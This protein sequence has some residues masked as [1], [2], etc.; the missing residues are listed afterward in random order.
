MLYT[1]R[2]AK[3]GPKSNTWLFGLGAKAKVSPVERVC[4]PFDDG[5]F[6]QAKGLNP[7]DPIKD[8]RTMCVNTTSPMVLKP[9]K[10]RKLGPPPIP[11]KSKT[12]IQIQGVHC[13]SYEPTNPWIAGVVSRTTTVNRCSTILGQCFEYRTFLIMTQDLAMCQHRGRFPEDLVVSLWFFFG[14]SLKPTL[15]AVFSGKG[16]EALLRP[17]ASLESIPFS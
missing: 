4:V 13:A 10:K 2:L 1:L 3:Y 8:C 14:F 6:L 16:G 9:P 17:V 5:S 11:L 12:S 15:K 7:D